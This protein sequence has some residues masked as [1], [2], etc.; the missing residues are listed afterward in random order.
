VEAWKIY[1][2][3]SEE[4][5]ANRDDVSCPA[6][7][8]QNDQKNEWIHDTTPDCEWVGQAVKLQRGETAILWSPEELVG[9]EE[10][11][12]ELRERLEGW[13][14][15]PPH[16]QTGI[17]YLHSE[18]LVVSGVLTRNLPLLTLPVKWNERNAASLMTPKHSF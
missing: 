4:A 8:H 7:V 9:L 10:V 17:A 11:Q 14:C 12:P 16:L 3:Q 1:H 2:E 13:L 15:L 18:G 5:V 6:S